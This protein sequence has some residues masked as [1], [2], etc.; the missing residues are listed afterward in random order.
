M[1]N[2][3]LNIL[4]ITIALG[5]GMGVGLS[6][7]TKAPPKAPPEYS[8]LVKTMVIQRDDA[9]TYRNYPGRV[10]AS[11]KVDLSFL[12]S[13]RLIQ[14]PVKESEQVKKN[15]LVATIDPKD[16]E[17]KVR[18]FKAKYDHALITYERYK[19]LLPSDA[20]S[21]AQ[22]DEK[23]SLHDLAKANLD[24]AQKSLDDTHL[25]APFAGFIANKY[26]ENHQ[27][28]R[29]NQKIVSLQD[30]AE[31]EIIINIP[32]QDIARAE[33]IEK[34]AT[35]TGEKQVGN[36][37]FAS[38][39]GKS[40]PV[41]VKQAQT[42]ADPKTQTYR[43][44]LIM[45]MPKDRIVLPGMTANVKMKFTS[46]Q[47]GYYIPSHAVAVNTT[48]GHFVWIINMKTMKVSSQIVDAGDMRGGKIHIRTGLKPGDRIVT[49]GVA[50]LDNGMQV[51]LIEGRIGR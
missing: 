22:Y 20:I 30:L 4:L 31:I 12:V 15:Q 48:G 1:V 38:I 28:V 50:Y 39:P 49:A 43:I 18:Q 24:E 41:R 47:E 33:E 36:V 13:G 27:F 23:K 14:F 17:I 40:F 9:G 34:L 37:T 6:G 44:T 42:E 26:V 51:K 7:C 29:A 5:V 35:E 32:E 11:Q 45:K 2:R 19:K 8:R 10:S 21:K 16:Y 25:Y 46:H 3:R